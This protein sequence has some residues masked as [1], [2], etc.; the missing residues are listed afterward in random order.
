MLSATAPLEARLGRRAAAAAVAAALQAIFYSLMVHEALEPTALQRSMPLAVTIFEVPRLASPTTTLPRQRPSRL[1]LPHLAIAKS[2]PL[3]RPPPARPITPTTAAEASAHPPVDW[4]QAAQRE[5]RELASRSHTRKMQFGFP[6]MP[7]S[8]PPRPQFG[9][10]YAHT[11]R[12]EPLPGGGTIINLTNRCA[13]VV[14]AIP[15]PVCKIGHIP[16]ND[17]LFDDMRDRRNDPRG[18]LP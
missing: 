7:E 10:D 9:W 11:H 4:Q 3:L 2:R 14:Y 8:A 12:V 15:I 6:Q 5:A 17:H 13:L 1:L 16:V 18:E